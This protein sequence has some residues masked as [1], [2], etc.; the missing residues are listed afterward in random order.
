MTNLLFNLFLFFSFLPYVG[1]NYFWF[2]VQPFSFFLGIFYIFS[3][4]KK[5]NILIKLNILII[6]LLPV[7]LC[8]SSVLYCNYD[9]F[10][11]T[12]QM[13]GYFSG[14]VIFTASY[15]G[16]KYNQEQFF[17]FVKR[18]F[19]PLIIVLCIISGIP[20]LFKIFGPFISSRGIIG[21]YGRGI[22]SFAAEASYVPSWMSII[23]LVDT[24]LNKVKQ[25]GIKIK[26]S[27]LSPICYIIPSFASKSGQLLVVFFM[28]ILSYISNA[29]YHFCRRLKRYKIQKLKFFDFKNFVFISL[30]L[31]I[32]SLLNRLNF[33][34]R[35]SRILDLVFEYGF[36]YPFLDQN[37]IIRTSSPLYQIGV[38]IYRP[39][40]LCPAKL[41][42]Y[43][44]VPAATEALDVVKNFV[45]NIQ[46]NL[47]STPENAD[48]LSRNL[49][50]ILGNLIVDF[51]LIGLIILILFYGLVIIPYIK[52]EGVNIISLLLL[53]VPFL[54]I[55]LAF[56]PFWFLMGL[57]Y[58]INQN[59]NEMQIFLKKGK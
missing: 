23:F 20:F 11:N 33:L 28:F 17:F 4:S 24:L 15:L 19:P 40:D 44:S 27:F 35:A 12:K 6:L 16:Y 30:G 39:F 45:S 41:N 47:F 25:N 54:N 56:P 51:G 59:K 46:H 13:Y 50:S 53:F 57:L 2:D 43:R 14:F 42:S 8:L 31:L 10:F 22:S 26:K 18:V 36:K 9:L 38:L 21:R 52:K 58:S 1:I 48:F 32:I 49:Y 37:V 34:G 55:S 7:L 3:A 5:H 29:F